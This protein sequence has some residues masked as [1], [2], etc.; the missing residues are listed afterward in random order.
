MVHIRKLL[1]AFREHLSGILPDWQGGDRSGPGSGAGQRPTNGSSYA[2]STYSTKANT[3][4]APQ[5]DARSTKSGKSGFSSFF[6][7][8]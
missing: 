7:R 5:T 1:P 2:P 6:K 8:G 4:K 3:L